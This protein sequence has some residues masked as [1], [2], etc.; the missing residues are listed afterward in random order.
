MAT[1]LLGLLSRRPLRGEYYCRESTYCGGSSVLVRVL[2]FSSI[3]I[4]V[5]CLWCCLFPVC[6]L[7]LD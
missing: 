5:A 6:C 7:Y 1:A 2:K 3:C 4:F